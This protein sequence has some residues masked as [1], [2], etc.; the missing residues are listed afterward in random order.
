MEKSIELVNDN[1]TNGVYLIKVF[2]KN[3]KTGIAKFVV[4]K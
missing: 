1:F 2:A 3:G 4:E